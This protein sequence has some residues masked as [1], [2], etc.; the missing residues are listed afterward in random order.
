MS[1]FDDVFAAAAPVFFDSFGETG[2]VEYFAT[3]GGS[4]VTWD[5]AIVDTGKIDGFEI[6]DSAGE[7]VTDSAFVTVDSATSWTTKGLIRVGGES[8]TLWHVVG[9]AMD[10]GSLITL[11]LSR[12]SN[13]VMRRADTSRRVSPRNR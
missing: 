2:G 13:S 10:S 4:P 1:A 12:T 11:A 6:A 9:L 7:R 8:G 3:A 5:D